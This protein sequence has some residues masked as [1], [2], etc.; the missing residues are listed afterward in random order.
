MKVSFANKRILIAAIPVVFVFLWST[1]FVNARLVMP[2]A[3]PFAFLSLRYALSIGLLAAFCQVTKVPW[4]KGRSFWVAFLIGTLIHAVYLSS[5]FWTVKRGFPAGF[6]GLI[7]GLQPIVTAVLAMGVVGERPGVRQWVGLAVGLVGVALVLGPKLDSP[8][9]ANT[10]FYALIVFGGV[11]AIALGTVLQKRF[12]GVKNLASETAVQYIGALAVSLPIAL[13]FESFVMVWNWQMIAGLTWLVGVL[14]VGAVVLLMV[15]IRAGEVGRVASLFYLVP[16]VSAI[17][18]FLLF[19]EQMNL[20]QIAGIAI[21]ST[22][23]ALATLRG[24][25]AIA[26]D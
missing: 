2:Y 23:V 21:T 4:P 3:D 7:V 9:G 26:A 19:G 12:G 18:A 22:G 5:V 16:A 13:V 8:L 25:R 14:S 17:L 10:I 6:A 1:G 20:V 24:K 11:A 15:L